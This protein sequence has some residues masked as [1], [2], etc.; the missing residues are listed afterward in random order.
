[1]NVR[2]T[3]IVAPAWPGRIA[4]EPR[5]K[6]A[7]MVEALLLPLGVGGELAIELPSGPTERREAYRHVGSCANKLW[8]SGRYKLSCRGLGNVMT[9]TRL[10]P[11][12]SAGEA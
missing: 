7:R 11:T 10:A 5:G 2:K 9:V 6:V 4:E 1:M 3:L 12:S 8:G